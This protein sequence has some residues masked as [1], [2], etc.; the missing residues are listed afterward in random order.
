MLEALWEFIGYLASSI[1]FIF[2]G[3]NVDRS[4]FFSN[5][6]ESLLLLSLLLLLRFLVVYGVCFLLNRVRGKRFQ[7]NWIR[8]FAW[9]G[10]RGAISIVLVLGTAGLL[11]NS[12][13]M[14]ALTF[15]I[16]VLSNVV[17][18]LSIGSVIKSQNLTFDELDTGDTEDVP[19]QFIE[20]YNPEGYK[21]DAPIIEKV[22]FNSPEFFLNE[23]KIGIWLS[24]TI[25]FLLNLVNK[26][27]ISKM[28]LSARATKGIGVYLLKGVVN[29]LYKISSIFNMN[30]LRN[31]ETEDI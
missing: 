4:V 30:I 24:R 8:G 5:M 23:T 15:G 1:A 3:T 18:G 21:F 19:V 2:I 9:S 28:S 11:E 17:Q 13:L 27:L 26:Y 7:G 25:I 31:E 6:L 14:I 12:G 10:L 29:I 16:V 20:H 22:I